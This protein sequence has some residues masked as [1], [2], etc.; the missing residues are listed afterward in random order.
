M[1]L[2]FANDYIFLLVEEQEFVDLEDK[3]HITLYFDGSKCEQG[4]GIGIIFITPQGVPIP[5]SF[6]LKFT[7]TNNIVEYDALV[8]GLQTAIKLNLKKIKIIGDS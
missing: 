5:L 2:D 6:T 7:C 4:G 1:S 3:I 8:L